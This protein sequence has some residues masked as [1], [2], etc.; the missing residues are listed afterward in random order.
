ML[1]LIFLLAFP[2]LLWKAWQ[3]HQTALASASWPQTTGTI[4][5]VERRKRLFRSYPE[6]SYRYSV[7]ENAY[8]SGRISFASGY[9]PAEVDAVME[10][11]SVGQNVPVYYAPEKPGE[12]V[13]EPGSNKQVTAPIRLLTICFVLL[14]ILNVARFYLGE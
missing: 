11:Y 6:V 9:R 2:F 10:R 3:T 8:G 12:A 13:L 1:S 14:I 7:G 4:I 5:K